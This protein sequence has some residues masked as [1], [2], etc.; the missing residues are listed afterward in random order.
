MVEPSGD[1][2]GAELVP[3]LVSAVRLEPLAAQMSPA[4]AK[5]MV[6]VKVGR[7]A[8][9][10]VMMRV[11]LGVLTGPMYGVESGPPLVPGSFVAPGPGPPGVEQQRDPVETA[12]GDGQQ[13]D[14]RDERRND[15]RRGAG[16]GP[17][18][19]G[20]SAVAGIAE[21]HGAATPTAA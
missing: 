15:G 20:V 11:G 17:G 6:P 5:R 18:P 10:G 16:R 9:G 12:G 7:S 14:D 3:L 4:R 19:S 1:Q 8:G 21:L 13:A 2:A